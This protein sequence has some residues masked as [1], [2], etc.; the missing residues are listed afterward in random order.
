[1]SVAEPVDPALVH[2]TA[3]VRQFNRFY[4][5]R[6]G[7]LQ[8][9]LSRSTFSLTEARVL[10]EL[11]HRQ[12]GDAPVTATGLG[13]ELGLDPGYLSRILRRFDEQGLVARSVAESDGRQVILTLTPA[14]AR[15]FAAIEEVTQ[16]EI[17]LMLRDLS[18]ADQRR[19][20]SAM[21][22]IERLLSTDRAPAAP[23]MLRP[24][25]AGD[26]GWIVHR[27]AALYALE[28]GW[29]QEYEALIAR[30]VAD[31]LDNFEPARE[32][33]WIA[34][35]DDAVVGSVFVVRHPEREGVAKLRLLYVEPSARGLGIGRRLV[36]ECARFARTSGYH[37]LTLWTNKVLVSARRIYEAEG[38]VLVDETP[39]HSFGHPQV[40]QTWDLRLQPPTDGQR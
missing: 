32:R 31:F 33:C 8:E 17:G 1:M 34:E 23:F 15:A 19:L 26:M 38:Y 10:L 18:D 39:H 20:V 28:Y 29:N 9:G 24:H 30:I 27:Q 14:G 21:A 5:K 6:I 4:T 22:E 12:G 37:T 35:R 7:L 25:G 11:A 40:G 16:G 36:Q 13:G 2:R 3:A